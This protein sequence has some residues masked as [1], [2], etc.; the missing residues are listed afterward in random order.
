MSPFVFAKIMKKFKSAK[1]LLLHP[2]SPQAPQPRS[3]NP[4][5]PEKRLSSAERREKVQRYLRKRKKRSWQISSNYQSRKKCAADRLRYKGRFVRFT[6]AV[7][8][9]T[10]QGLPREEIDRLS[11]SALQR[12]LKENAEIEASPDKEG[13]KEK[14]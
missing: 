3:L 2:H 4:Y 5:L 7:E 13:S 8:I 1:G 14:L 12:L 9:L 6:R 11:N 10:A